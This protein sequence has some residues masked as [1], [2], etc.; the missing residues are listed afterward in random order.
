MKGELSTANDDK[1]TLHRENEALRAENQKLRQQLEMAHAAASTAASSPRSVPP[2][3]GST[4]S[5]ATKASNGLDVKETASAYELCVNVPGAKIS[6]L[7]ISYGN[8]AL[9][10]NAKGKKY[11]FNVAANAIQASKISATLQPGGGL[12]ITVPKS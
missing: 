1:D 8:G 4:G 7:K 5:P 6:D 3:A 12:Q 2:P 11:E 10:L 9:E